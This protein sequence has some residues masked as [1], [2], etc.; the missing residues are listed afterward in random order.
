MKRKVKKPYIIESR[1]LPGYWC[2]FA[3]SYTWSRWNRYK[4]EK[5]R[6][7]ALTALRQSHRGMMQFRFA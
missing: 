1:F 3:W 7:K 2:E 4:T 5:D 6:L